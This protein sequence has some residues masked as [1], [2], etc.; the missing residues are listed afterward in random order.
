V[1]WLVERGQRTRRGFDD[2]GV[3]RVKR[4]L[5]AGG[6]GPVGPTSGRADPALAEALRLYRDESPNHRWRLEAYLLT[7]EPMQIVANRCLVSL[8]T[9]QTYHE[10]FCDVRPHRAARDWVWVRAI[11][12]G[13][14]NGF[15]RDFPGS[16]WK[17]FAYA[18]GP[19]ALEL[20]VAVTTDACLPGWV[21][22]SLTL[23][24]PYH[25][26]RLRL[27]GKLAIAALTTD[28]PGEWD[29][30]VEARQQLRELD[31]RV[32]ETADETDGMVPAMENFLQAVGGRRKRD[33]KTTPRRPVAGERAYPPGG[34]S[35]AG[36]PQSLAAVL[37]ALR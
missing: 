12:A 22:E 23:N 33:R 7:D 34:E 32:P 25:E 1:S 17:G 8:E 2:D 13:P 5:G 9:A 3:R 18:A 14:W 26:A 36:Q 27:L 4:F 30:L 6:R 15:G 11:G 16:L 35:Q 19:L 20:A 21:R 24:S 28:S 29:A 10:I 37:D 31:R